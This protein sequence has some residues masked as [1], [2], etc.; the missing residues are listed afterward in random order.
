VVSVE[1]LCSRQLMMELSLAPLL[2]LVLEGL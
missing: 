1:H 2:E